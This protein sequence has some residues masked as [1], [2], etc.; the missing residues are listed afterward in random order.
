VL[1]PAGDEDRRVRE[2]DNLV[3]GSALSMIA[4]PAMMPRLSGEFHTV[5]E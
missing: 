4:L 1:K 2:V 3:V 5:F